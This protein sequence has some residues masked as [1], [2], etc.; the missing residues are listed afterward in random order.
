MHPAIQLDAI[1]GDVE[2]VVAVEIHR[3]GIFLRRGRRHAEGGVVDGVMEVGD[4]VV[5]HDMTLAIDL[6]GIFAGDQ[7]G[8]LAPLL[9]DIIADPAGD[10]AGIVTAQEDVVGDVI[11]LRPGPVVAHHPADIAGAAVDQGEAVGADDILDAQH[12]GDIGVLHRDAVDIRVVGSFQIEQRVI[13]GAVEHHLAVARRLDDDGL[14]GCAAGGQVIGAVKRSTI[15]LDALVE[16]AIDKAAVFIRAG[17]DQDGIARLHPRREDIV[18][19]A[20]VGAQIIGRQK[21]DKVV[22]P[23]RALMAVRPHVIYVT[24]GGRFRHGAGLHGD[25]LFRPA[26]IRVVHHEMHVIFRGRFQP[27]HAAGKTRRHGV[28]VIIGAELRLGAGDE[29]PAH[30]EQRQR[31]LPRRVAGLA[32]CDIDRR[33][34]VVVAADLP[35]KAQRLQRGPL[36]HEFARC[37]GIGSLCRAA[38]HAQHRRR[39]KNPHPRL[40]IFARRLGRF[41]HLGNIRRPAP[42]RAA[43]SWPSSEPA[44]AAA[45]AS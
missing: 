11:I 34:A 26:A 17:M 2:H 3:R 36:D 18:M 29:L 31:L 39:Q 1:V 45:A 20:F 12:E 27:Q 10:A 15:A 40:P 41:Q 24:A 32:V 35:F 37:H 42:P 5:R 43:R 14:V 13:V 21:P 23:Q 8:K 4:I 30:A 44:P 33:I 6:H 38:R 16:A 19:V 7:R 28:I 25:R 22:R 9:P